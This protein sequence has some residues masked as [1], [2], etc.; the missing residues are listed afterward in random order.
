M[1]LDLTTRYMG[2][3]LRNPIVASA[4]PFGRTV[5]GVW[6]TRVW[7]GRGRGVRRSTGFGRGWR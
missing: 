1:D 3:E 4:G 5:D 7:A 2:L 6:P